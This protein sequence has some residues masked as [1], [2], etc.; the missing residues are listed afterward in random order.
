[1]QE[2]QN[3]KRTEYIDVISAIMLIFMIFT[4]FI[5]LF[6]Y[7]DNLIYINSFYVFGSY[8]VW[9]FFKAGSF[10]KP[11]SMKENILSSYKRLIVPYIKWMIIGFFVLLFYDYSV[12]QYDSLF[13]YI[14]INITGS[15]MTGAGSANLPLWF[16]VSLFICRIIYNWAQSKF[17]P[18]RY[19]FGK[20][21]A[22][23]IF[24]S[25]R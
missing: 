4:H 9:F 15:I 17:A 5:Q 8:M 16:L 19:L 24:Q 11:K 20:F 23:I 18:P 6:E 1:M 14:R 21:Y 2:I 7:T 13:H 25:H 22:G 12:G 10:Y 3:K